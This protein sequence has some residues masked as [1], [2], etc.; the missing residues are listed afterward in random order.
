MDALARI[1]K[2]PLLPMNLLR[3]RSRHRSC[4]L[5]LRH[6]SRFFCE[7]CM[8]NPGLAPSRWWPLPP[9]RPKRAACGVA[10]LRSGSGQHNPQCSNGE[11]VGEQAATGTLFHLTYIMRRVVHPTV[12][13][14]RVLGFGFPNSFRVAVRCC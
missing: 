6:P 7:E 8:R 10:G 5:A 1:I 12:F 11:S 13:M 14:A 3:R 2:D 4:L 9:L